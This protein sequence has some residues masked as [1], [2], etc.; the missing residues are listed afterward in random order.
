M[1]QALRLFLAGLVHETNSFSPLPTSV[2]SYADEGLLIRRREPQALEKIEAQAVLGGVLASARRNGDTLYP[3]RL[4]VSDFENYRHSIQRLVDFTH[5]KP[6]AH[7]LG[8]HIEQASTPFLDYPVGTKYQPEEHTLALSH[9]HLVELNEALRGMN[10]PV[11]RYALRDF[12]IWPQVRRA[13]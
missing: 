13:N 2:A 8:C 6:V 9:A 3:G 11:V 10:G 5:D 1:S 4:Y 7:I 12:T